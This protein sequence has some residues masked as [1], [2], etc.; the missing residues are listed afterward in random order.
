MQRGVYP[1]SRTVSPV[2]TIETRELNQHTSAGDSRGDLH[3]VTIRHIPQTD[4]FSR[5][6]LSK[7]AICTE[8]AAERMGTPGESMFTFKVQSSL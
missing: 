7:L 4:L 5:R 3:S 8:M 6:A 2:P 1:T